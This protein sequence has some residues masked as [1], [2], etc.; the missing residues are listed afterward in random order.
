MI[1]EWSHNGQKKNRS[2]NRRRAIQTFDSRVWE[3]FIH[4]K[5]LEEIQ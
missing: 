1:N 3:I 4:F 5:K 2:S